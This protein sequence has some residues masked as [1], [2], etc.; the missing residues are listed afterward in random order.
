MLLEDDDFT[1]QTIKNALTQNKINVV[2][3][4]ATVKDAIDFAKSGHVDVTVIDY[5]LGRG[6]NGIDAAQALV[7]IQP[8]MGFVLLTGFLDPTV[9]L[10]S[11]N[12]LPA[13]SRYLLKQNLQD[14]NQLI[15]EIKHASTTVG[16]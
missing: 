10:T 9:V 6:P 12:A 1:R 3:D 14:I 5:N 4:A 13:G 7:K 16:I 2:C 8:K 15:A 11:M